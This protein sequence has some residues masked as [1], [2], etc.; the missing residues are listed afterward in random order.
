MCGIA[1]IWRDSPG[2]MASDVGAMLATL[3]H[4]GP[5]DQGTFVDPQQVLGLGHRRLSI[6]DLSPAGHQPMASTGQRYQLVFNGEIYNY[7]LLRAELEQQYPSIAWRGHADTEVLLNAI[8]HW[9][10]ESTLKRVNGM[11]ALALWDT[12]ARQLTLARDRIG[13]KPLYY[14]RVGNAFVFASESQAFATLPGWQAQIDRPALAAYLRHAFVP[15]P[16]CLWQG[17]SQLPPGHLLTLTQSK[18]V[19]TPRPYWQL[20]RATAHRTALDMDDR[21]YLKQLE[22]LLLDSI[23]LRCL[24][25]VPLGAFLSGGIDSSL[26]VSLMAHAQNTPIDTFTIGF[27]DPRLNEAE[28]AL[29]IAKHL[30]THHNVHIFSAQDALQGAQQLAQVYDQPLADPSAIPTVMLCQMARQQVGVCLS[31]D[32]GDELFCGYRK[33]RSRLRWWQR[34]EKIPYPL[35]RGLGALLKA[36]PASRFNVLMRDWRQRSLNTGWLLGDKIHKFLPLLNADTQQAFYADFMSHWQQPNLLLPGISEAGSLLHDDRWPQD[37]AFVDA[38]MWADMHQYL[39]DD[40]L[41]K[42]DRASMHHSLEVRVPLLDHRVIEFAWQSPMH[43][44]R[45]DGQSKWALRQLL[46]QHVPS[47]LTNRPKQGFTPPLFAWLRE[48]L[49]DWAYDL[50]FAPEHNIGEFFAKAPLQRAW[51]EHQQHTRNWQYTL[52]PVILFQAWRQQQNTPLM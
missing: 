17:I 34:L 2:R 33:Y 22:S 4:R 19:P 1:G 51:Q 12:Q 15:H 7:R 21:S 32:G 38:M 50:L 44:K 29:A 14:G 16:H 46:A 10:L 30:G 5:D 42:V 52:W 37:L 6:L 36:I 26:I 28:H 48:D 8:S 13:E 47:A 40:I 41:M 18:T 9:G 35:K 25:D 11:F 3:R 39:P 20:T 27:N 45:R 23:Q 24:S 31:G 49:K 43:V